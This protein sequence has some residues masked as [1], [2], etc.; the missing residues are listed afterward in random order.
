MMNGNVTEST[1]FEII[2]ELS[3]LDEDYTG[4]IVRSQSRRKPRHEMEIEWVRV[5]T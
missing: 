1:H 4:L 5:T 3:T 2:P